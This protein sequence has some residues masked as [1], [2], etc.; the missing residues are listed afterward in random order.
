[1]TSTLDSHFAEERDDEA[2]DFVLST[3]RATSIRAE[4]VVAL[5]AFL[6][7]NKVDVKV[8]K[9]LLEVAGWTTAMAPLLAGRTAVKR[10]D[11]AEMLAAEAAE[12][13]DGMLVPVRK[14]RYQIDPN[15]TLPGSDV[16]GFVV[17]EDGAIVDLEFIESK[18]R[19][20]PGQDI[21]VEAH[22]Q[23][24]NDRSRGYATTIHF[25]AS[26]L[27]EL[28][29][30]LYA[31]FLR[32]LSLR[33]LP[34]SRH[35]VVITCDEKNWREDIAENLNDLSSHLPEL[36]LRVFRLDSAGDLVDAVYSA[37]LWDPVDD[38]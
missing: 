2:F 11:F 29:P 37:L 6:E 26:R 30:V 32:F 5:T 12:A 9:D 18:Y 19:T 22:E 35:T 17:D 28:D 27:N 1:M 13:M 21:A 36:W 16:V 7:R 10:G 25:L 33:T 14:L 8:T 24:A 31:D 20:K 4:L 34:G 3:V 15:Q 38:D 23:L